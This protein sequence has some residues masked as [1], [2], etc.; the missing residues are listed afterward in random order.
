MEWVSLGGGIAFTSENYPVDRFCERFKRF[1]SDF[2]LQLYLE[3]GDDGKWHEL[4]IYNNCNHAKCYR[5]LESQAISYTAGVPPIAA[6]MLVARGDWAP[7]T[8]V[9]VEE[10]TLSRF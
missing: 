3:P 4:L 1:A 2:G 8:M 9:N 10:L 7:H 6:A 5:E